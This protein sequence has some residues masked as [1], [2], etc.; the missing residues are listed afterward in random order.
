[1]WTIQRFSVC[2]E[3]RRPLL[4]RGA[5][6]RDRRIT[7]SGRRASPGAR[8]P[9]TVRLAVRFDDRPGTWIFHCHILDHADGGLLSAVHL[10]LPPEKFRNLAEHRRTH[11]LTRTD[12]AP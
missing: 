5:G 7:L 11:A 10:D 8:S 2:R 4:W 6:W 12:F 9:L 1:M 3:P